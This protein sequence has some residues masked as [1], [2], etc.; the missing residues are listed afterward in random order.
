V[1]LSEED[2]ERLDDAYGRRWI[3]RTHCDFGPPVIARR[4]QLQPATW[5][6]EADGW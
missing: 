6:V 5:E 2:V 3:A 1:V 4:A